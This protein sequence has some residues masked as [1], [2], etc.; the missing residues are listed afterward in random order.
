MHVL[1]SRHTQTETSPIY[2]RIYIEITVLGIIINWIH[3]KKKRPV[4]ATEK[5]KAPT[6]KTC[7]KLCYRYLIFREEATSIEV[8]SDSETMD[9]KTESMNTENTGANYKIM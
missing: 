7:I 2:S 6:V 3:L 9:D 5:D 8:D 4:I 1:L